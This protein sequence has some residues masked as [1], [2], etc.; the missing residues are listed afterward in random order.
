[1][2]LRVERMVILVISNGKGDES[3]STL[4]IV[5]AQPHARQL[6]LIMSFPTP[7]TFIA[8]VIEWVGFC[9][10]SIVWHIEGRLNQGSAVFFFY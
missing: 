4:Y 3:T 7:I 9:V 8:T 2:I 5:V 1:M 6:L 10:D